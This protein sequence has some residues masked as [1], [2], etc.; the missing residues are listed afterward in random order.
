MGRV[1]KSLE[2]IGNGNII[3]F[4]IGVKLLGQRGAIWM[5][6][7]EKGKG[8]LVWHCFTHE[9]IGWEGEENSRHLVELTTL[10][11]LQDNNNKWV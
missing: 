5:K 7:D 6:I 10:S 4:V 9:S 3:V 2:V 11:H 8:K 1:K